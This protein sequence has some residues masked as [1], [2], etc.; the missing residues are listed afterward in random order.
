MHVAPDQNGRD[1]MTMKFEELDNSTRGF[2]LI[3][4]EGEEASGIPYRSKVLTFA[5]LVAFPNLMREAIRTGNEQPL[6][7]S[8]LRADFWNES[9]TYIRGG[10]MRERRLNIQQAAERLA[11]NEFNTWY[12]RGLTKRL[13]EEGV[14]QCQAYRGALPKWEPGECS[15]HEGQIFAV[16]AIYRNHRARYWPEPGNPKAASIPFGPGCHHTIRRVL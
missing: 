14:A 9:E 2:M 12:V 13:M 5:G 1:E 15:T 16:E 11:L 3:E 10:V 4:F 7:S 6:G 8:L